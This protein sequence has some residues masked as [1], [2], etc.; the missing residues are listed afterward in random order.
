MML[1]NTVFMKHIRRLSYGKMYDNK[2]WTNRLIMNAIYELRP[3]ESWQSRYENKRLAEWMKP[4][5]LIQQN[6]KKAADMGTTLWFTDE[7]KSNG[8]PEAIVA[9][10]QYN[11]CWNLLAYI[12]RLEHNNLNTDK[13]HELITKCKDQLIEDWTKFK[14]DPMWLFKEKIG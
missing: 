13:T 8:M 5:E 7:D 6:S 9:A 14:E 3:G 11:I 1:T 12:E 4:S 10:G 2:R